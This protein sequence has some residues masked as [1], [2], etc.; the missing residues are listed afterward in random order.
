MK[1]KTTLYAKNL[2]RQMLWCCVGFD[3]TVSKI[4]T[5]QLTPYSLDKNNYV[6]T[7]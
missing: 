4:L 3:F 5:Q 2:K 7:V 1:K 6:N